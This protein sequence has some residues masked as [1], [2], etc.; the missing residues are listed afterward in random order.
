MELG[1]FRLLPTRLCLIP[2][3]NIKVGIL[4]LSGLVF[5]LDNKFLKGLISASHNDVI[6]FVFSVKRT[7]K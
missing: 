5:D 7:Q 4:S 6:F 1:A 2:A 3:R